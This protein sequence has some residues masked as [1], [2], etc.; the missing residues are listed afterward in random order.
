VRCGAAVPTAP[1]GPAG[2]PQAAGGLGTHRTRAPAIPTVALVISIEDLRSGDEEAAH[3]LGRQAFGGT[4]DF[5]PERPSVG[6]GRHL[7]AYRDGVLVG[8]VRRHRFGQ[9]FG[10]RR[11]ACAGISGVVV[12]PQARGR[13]VARRM[14]TE[15]LDRAAAD[16]EVVAALYPTTAALYRSV[17]FEVAGWWVQRGVPV[18][19][20]PRDDGSVTWERAAFDD[21]RAVAVYERM[22]PD[23]D[24][25]LDPGSQFWTW[26]AMHASKD[27]KANRYLYVG[28]R[29]AEAVAAVQYRHAD[30]DR[31]MY[32][33]DVEAV[34]GVDGAA[35]RAALAFL[36]AN[37]TTADEVRTVLPT[38]EL[39]LHLAHAQRTR[40][41]ESWP[42]MLAFVDLPGAV[43]AR[44][45]STGVT[46]AVP[47]AVDD[48]HR[49]GNSG[50]WVLA[51]GDGR[52]SLEPG[53]DG[54][55]EVAAADLAAVFTGHL[56]PL[57]L[58]RAGRLG[59][60]AAEDIDLLRAA[61]AG[62]PSLTIFF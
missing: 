28:V 17:G 41:H 6:E 27:D 24:G 55:V 48:P 56:D 4:D 19:E 29:G 32:R 3:R 59:H 40:V 57:R 49:P 5:D 16:G 39:E 22:A 15:S 8:Q 47:L 43:A 60:P 61:F 52:A 31:A 9:W 12:A 23:H 20:L 54:R 33:L 13:D 62:H 18:G 44:G 34:Q 42:W 10:G 45:Y 37:G 26:R 21:P 53:G 51:V 58:A 46:G 30:S 35:V 25:W 11:L 50:K 38:D 36:G 14:L 2:H 1:P 7:A